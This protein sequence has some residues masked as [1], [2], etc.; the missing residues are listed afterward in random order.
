MRGELCKGDDAPECVSQSP[1]YDGLRD[2]DAETTVVTPFPTLWGTPWDP[3]SAHP[4][5]HICIQ[6]FTVTFALRLPE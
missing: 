4:H 1:A 5:K 2:G 3:L 6:E